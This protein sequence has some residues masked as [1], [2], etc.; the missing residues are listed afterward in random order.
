MKLLFA[1]LS[2]L[3]LLGVAPVCAFGFV[4][5]FEPADKTTQFM[6]FRIGFTLV[7]LACLVGARILL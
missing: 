6:A 7:G 3:L 5:T 1:I 2:S 4:A